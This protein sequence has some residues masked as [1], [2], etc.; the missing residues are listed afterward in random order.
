MDDRAGKDVTTFGN[1][2]HDVLSKERF[3]NWIT[4]EL[5]INEQGDY[6]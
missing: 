4:N 2:N 6:Y 1:K 3:N 5:A